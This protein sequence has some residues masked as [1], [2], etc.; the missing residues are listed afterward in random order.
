MGNFPHVQ[1]LVD[2]RAWISPSR[3]TRPVTHREKDI[4]NTSK[5]NTGLRGG[6]AVIGAVAG[7]TVAVATAA[8]APAPSGTTLYICQDVKNSGNYRMSIK[9]V[10]PMQQADATGYLIHVNDGIRPGGPGPG[11]MIYHIV[12]DDGDGWPGDRDIAPSTFAP[13]TQTDGEGYLR[14]GPDGI[15]YL[16]EIS[17]PRKNFDEDTGPI[18]TDDELYAVAMFRDG[19][20]GERIAFSQKI[21]RHFEDA[22]ICN[23][24]CT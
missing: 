5:K 14:P 16:R 20:G 3:D 7:L 13:G 6:V 23:G 8:A 12:A 18:N 11:G 1:A 22:G 24:C 2:E 4:V 17:V 10:F 21:V 9:G 15:E 19:D